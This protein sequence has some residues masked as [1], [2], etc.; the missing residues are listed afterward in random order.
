M[1]DYLYMLH[2]CCTQEL[3]IV[4]GAH[5]MLHCGTHLVSLSMY[6]DE[7]HTEASLASLCLFFILAT[8]QV[9]ATVVRPRD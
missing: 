2:E 3:A 6:V 9:H 4:A 1:I 5:E 8:N 7:S